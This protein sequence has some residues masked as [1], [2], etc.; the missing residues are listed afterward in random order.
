M[1]ANTSD[2]KALY[3]AYTRACADYA[4]GVPPASLEHL[5]VAQRRACRTI[6]GCLRSTP[7]AALERQADLMPFAARRRQL[8]AAQRHLR[9]LPGDPLQPLLQVTASPRPGLEVRAG[10]GLE[11]LRREPTLMAPLPHRG[12]APWRESAST[13][14]PS[15]PPS[16]PMMMMIMI[17]RA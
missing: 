6:T 14:P 7:A 3:L 11:G 2:L 13:P 1:G 17:I 10:A 16:E 15:G 12:R 4:A 9:D 8:A 5:E